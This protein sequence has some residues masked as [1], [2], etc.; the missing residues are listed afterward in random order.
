MVRYGFAV[1]G[2][3]HPASC[4]GCPQIGL[5]A[6][7]PSAHGCFPIRLL[8]RLYGRFKADFG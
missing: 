4:P 5:W 8:K 7:R 3:I 2:A 6:H 1:T